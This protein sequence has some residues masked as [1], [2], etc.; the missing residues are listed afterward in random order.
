[1]YQKTSKYIYY[2]IIFAFHCTNLFF[3][4][5]FYRF[6]FTKRLGV[7]ETVKMITEVDLG[8]VHY[9]ELHFLHFFFSV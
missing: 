8:T 4:P 5:M 1:M 6:F 2:S 3:I 7:L 9:P